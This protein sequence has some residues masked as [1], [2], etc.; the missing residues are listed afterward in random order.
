MKRHCHIAQTLLVS[1]GILLLTACAS[2]ISQFDTYRAPGTNTNLGIEVIRHPRTPPV[3]ELKINE[4][5]VMDLRW[6][7]FD[8]HRTANGVYNGKPVEMKGS[9]TPGTFTI[10]VF[11][12]HD[13]AANFVFK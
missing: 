12:D 11:I 2:I 5:H 1:S 7:M 10:D 8:Y 4:Q 13:R 6:T 9:F 3:F